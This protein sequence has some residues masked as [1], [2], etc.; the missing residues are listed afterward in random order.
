MFSQTVEYALRAAAHLGSIYPATATTA[1]IANVTKVPPAYLAKVLQSM[2]DSQLVESRRGIGGGIRLASDPA[3]MCIL[4]IV[5]SV[6]PV[7]RIHTCPLGLKAHSKQLCPL[8]AKMDAAICHV[9]DAFASTTLA[10]VLN[11]DG[12]AG[13]KPLCDE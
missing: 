4:D 3:E 2:R 1:E 6:E 7:Q 12:K 5:N 11:G 9:E 10:E 8:H 13:V